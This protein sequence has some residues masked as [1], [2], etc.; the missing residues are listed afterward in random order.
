MPLRLLAIAGIAAA[1]H[2]EGTADGRTTCGAMKQL[3]KDL[4]CCGNPTTD[5]DFTPI[6][7]PMNRMTGT[8]YCAGTKSLT[9]P[10]LNNIDCFVDAVRQAGEQAGADITAGFEGSLDSDIVPI[11]DRYYKTALCPVNVHWHLGA[12]HRS[13]GQFDEG[14][15]A[16]GAN[17]ANAPPHVAAGDRRLT[18]YAEVRYGYACRHYD[19]DD[20]KFT[21]EYDWQHCLEMNV[22]E[23]Y[24]VH[25][26]HSSMGACGT[27]YQY[28]SPFYD[29]VFCGFGGELP[30]AQGIASN[31]GVQGQVFTIVN[32]ENYYYPDLIRGMLVDAEH[33][34]GIDIAVY[35]GSTTGTSRDA[36]GTCSA[37]TPITWQV[38][39]TCHL[40][41]ASSF[42]K[43]CF[44]MKQM[45]ADMSSDLHPHGARELVWQNLT[46]DN[47]ADM[48]DAN[49]QHGAR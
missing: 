38:D 7:N 21:T 19:A 11:M 14:G 15:S 17:Y 49:D 6:P 34:I 37:Y 39:R 30:S 42:D 33:E 5:I 35:T 22:G 40:I 47:L 4:E 44:D 46:A 8:N 18:D 24:E 36:G 45:R 1:D 23:T 12:E 20:A 28:Q 27:P 10:T 2:H 16:P 48:S 32:D 29:G 3:Y 25:W 43:M 31:I 41:S 13:E 9:E 26:P